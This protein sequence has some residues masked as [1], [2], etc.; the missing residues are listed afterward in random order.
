LGMNAASFDKFVKQKYGSSRTVNSA[1]SYKWPNAEVPYEMSHEFTYE[2]RAVIASAMQELQQRT[3]VT[4]VQ[5]RIGHRNWAWIQPGSGGCSSYVGR[6]Y[7]REGAQE[8]NLDQSECMDKK[9]VQ[10]ELMHLLGFE[11]EHQR[12]DRD[13]YVQFFVDNI[14]SR[15][16]TNVHSWI[17]Q[18][19]DARYI[20]NL[21]Q[22]DVNSVMHYASWMFSKD[23]Q[24]MFNHKSPT[25]LTKSGAFIN[26]TKLSD[27]DWKRISQYYSCPNN[28]VAQDASCA[29]TQTAYNCM[30]WKQQGYCASSSIYYSYNLIN[31]RKTCGFC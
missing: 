24:S 14:S 28:G 20:N 19:L 16:G 13:Q 25:V 21:S 5:R 10:H 30:M 27:S 26:P 6:Q 3:C 1:E 12:P 22:Y 4:F 29:D 17:L 2:S 31:C 9:T 18:K 7:H 23:P 15:V 8:V 11:H